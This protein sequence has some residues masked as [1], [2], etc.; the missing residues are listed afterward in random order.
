M[1]QAMSLG[2]CPPLE[3]KH[4]SE[5]FIGQIYISYVNY[6]LMIAT[7]AIVA[8]FGTSSKIPKKLIPFFN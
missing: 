8:G 7:I 5:K 4:T 3:I 1:S 2:S 6:P